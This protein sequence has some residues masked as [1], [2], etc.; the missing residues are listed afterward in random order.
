VGDFGVSE[1]NRP[2]KNRGYGRYAVLNEANDASQQIVEVPTK[3]RD[4]Y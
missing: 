4:E 2:L 1:S 3:Q